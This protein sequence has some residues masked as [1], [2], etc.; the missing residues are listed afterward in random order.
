MFRSVS[1]RIVPIWGNANTL[2]DIHVQRASK[3][4]IARCR[5][6]ESICN[7]VPAPEVEMMEFLPMFSGKN[8]SDES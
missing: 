5:R 8:N 6:L 4:S 1:L 7:W 3:W 2:A